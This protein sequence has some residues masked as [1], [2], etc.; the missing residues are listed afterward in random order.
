MHQKAA[1]AEAYVSR[2]HWLVGVWHIADIM[3]TVEL[4]FR[5][6]GHYIARESTSD[7]LSGTVRGRYTLEPKQLRQV[8]R[9]RYRIGPDKATLA[10]YAG[11]GSG[12]GQ[13]RGFELDLYD[14]DL[15]LIGDSHRMV[16]AR[17]VP[18][19][20]AAVIEKTR[21]PQA[22]KGERGAILGL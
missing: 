9:G 7:M 6:D 5:P 21:D 4:T 20:D 3:Q 13:P 1:E 15:F 8:E 19:S 14:G 22:M 16:V 10:P 18:G 12:F 11:L 17:K 2:A